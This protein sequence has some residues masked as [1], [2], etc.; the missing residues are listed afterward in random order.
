MSGISSFL[1]CFNFVR[2][3]PVFS[4]LNWFDHQRIARKAIIVEYKK[5]DIIARQDS[6]PDYFYCLISGRLQAYSELNE[7]KDNIEFIHRGM[8]FGIIS[9][10]TG[11]NHSLT[12]EAIN[13]SVVL[14][15]PK[16]EFER[17]LKSMPQLA[18]ELSQN[19]SQRVRRNVTGKKTIFQSTIISI[20]SPVTGTGSSTYA[21]NLA[22]S[23]QKETNKKIIFVSIHPSV[24]ST[25]DP[26]VDSRATQASLEWKTPPV[27]VTEIVGDHERIMQSVIK[28]DL[29]IDLL[30]VY[31]EKDDEAAKKQISP[32]VS[33]LVGDYHYVVVD[34]PNHMDEKVITTLT[35][36]DQVH[37]LVT[38][39][40][41]DLGMVRRV[42]DQLELNL[43]EKFRAE[44]IKVIIR[45]HHERMYLTFEE[46]DK[47]IDYSV[48]T[49]LPS[50]QRED[51]KESLPSNTLMFMQ[52]QESSEYC[53][54][55]R[56]IAREIGGVR[57]GLVLGGGAALGVAHIGVIR[58]LERENIPVDMVVGSSMGALVAAI[59]CSGKNAAELELVARE[60]EKKLNML[61]LFDPVI[62]ISGL[63]GGRLIKRWLRKHLGDKTFYSSTIPLKIITYDLIRREEVVVDSG[64]LV[65]AVRKSVAIP[66]VI[67]PVKVGDQVLIDGGVLNPLPTNVCAS[68]GI[69]KIIAVNVLQSPEDCSEGFDIVKRELEE[70]AKKSFWRSPLGYIGFRINRGLMRFLS[71]NISDIIV[72]TLQAT[73]Y[74]I[75]EQSA[76]QA[77]IYMHPDLVGI[78]WFELNRVDELIAAGEKAAENVLP[79]LKSLV[80]AEQNKPSAA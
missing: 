62:P 56:R 4:S 11:E 13:D 28:N 54:T 35:Q 70:K 34:L 59:W 68:R 38:D 22:L 17:L 63:I 50:V 18:I 26:S 14:Q 5:G 19:L 16:T 49:S 67:T 3:I 80:S 77:D 61:K 73:E 12:F 74:V 45:A 72:R 40:K 55:V 2:Q 25:E 48:Y 36:S 27:S 46:I 42:I 66:G 1:N 10:L 15:I 24:R 9:L 33:A 39:K 37:L 79:E 32:L 53:K 51:L 65:D 31:F 44:A 58:V 6:P 30:N 29:P 23:L 41:K 7:I 69:N 8:H 20:Y 78:N 47:S 71:P 76:R 60:F 64:S 57:V 52:C 21:A 75:S 43:K